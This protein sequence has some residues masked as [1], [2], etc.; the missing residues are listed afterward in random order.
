[1]HCIICETSA[2][3]GSLAGDQ[4]RLSCPECGDYRITRSALKMLADGN[5]RFE[6]DV[7]RIWLKG[8]R[9]TGQTPLIDWNLVS[10]L[11]TR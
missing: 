11:A 8:R 9:C 5:Y 3:R 4:E 10:V 2:R 7:A 6:V 1:M